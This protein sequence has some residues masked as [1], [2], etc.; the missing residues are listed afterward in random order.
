[1]RTLL[2]ALTLLLLLVPSLDAAEVDQVVELQEGLIELGYDIGE[3]D[4]RIGERTRA[5]IIA[6][7]RDHDFEP[8]GKYSSVLLEQVLL[9]LAVKRIPE[10]QER[11]KTHLLAKTNAQLRFISIC[12]SMIGLLSAAADLQK[13]VAAVQKGDFATALRELRPLAEHG[14]PNAQNLLGVMDD[15]AVAERGSSPIAA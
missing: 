9:T 15:V 13:G 12:P 11:K 1:M 6:F 8:D 14:N 2:L 7:Q 4:G 3:S 5:A 10:M